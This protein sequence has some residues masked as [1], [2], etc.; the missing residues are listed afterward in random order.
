MTTITE[1]APTVVTSEQALEGLLLPKVE[2]QPESDISPAI[3]KQADKLVA[4]LLKVEPVDLREQDRQSYAITNLGI[5]VQNKIRTQSKML[6]EPMR[7]LVSDAE[8]GGVI[9]KGL[10]SLQEQVN[11]I[12]PSKI[13]FTMGTI[14]RLLVMIPGIGTPISRWFQRYQSVKT[15]IDD[16]VRQLKDGKS[17]LERD[18]NTL[19]EDQIRM[20]ELTR[21]LTD[22]S[23]LG[24]VMA[25]KL[26]ASIDALP[27]D[28]A[29]RKFLEEEVLFPLNQRV[30][31]IQQQLATNQIGAVS[32]EVIIR[33]NRELIKGVDRSLNVTIVALEVA[34]ILQ[35]ALKRQKKTLDA[36]NAVN[37]TTS[38][39]LQH[40]AKT[41]KTQGVEIQ[42][43][44]ST[45]QLD[46]EKLKNSF[47]DVI[48]AMDDISRFR[49]EA[50]PGMAKS[51]LDMDNMTEEMNSVMDKMAEGNKKSDALVIE[52]A[53]A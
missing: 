31:D 11:I 53:S 28:D 44:A 17:Q 50:L 24:Q 5:D 49:R 39:I 51:I 47:R 35:V 48:S 23:T 26:Q 42:K 18:N 40:A 29:R 34:S 30:I 9:G 3:I 1:E 20:I 14:R 43:Q 32:S 52:I 45:A 36:V 19:R 46:I 21:N 25:K 38:E 4:N 13:D 12:N 33:N 22:Y 6:A 16:I 37:E 2:A 8:D 10:L 41:V 15:V 7:S 27:V